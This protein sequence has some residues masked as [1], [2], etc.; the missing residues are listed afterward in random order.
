M[1]GR[2]AEQKAVE[3][4]AWQMPCNLTVDWKA[5]YIE[6]VEFTE[7]FANIHVRQKPS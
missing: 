4:I 2:E 3:L 5:E 1:K 7:V 6:L